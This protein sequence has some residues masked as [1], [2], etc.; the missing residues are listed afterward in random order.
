MKSKL[1]PHSLLKTSEILKKNIENQ[2]HLV[3]IQ[4]KN[5]RFKV[6]SKENYGNF[7][8]VEKEYYTIKGKLEDQNSFT[9]ISYQVN[10]NSIFNT[11]SII[12]PIMALP[13]AIIPMIS[14]GKAY[15]FASLIGYLIVSS[16]LIIIFKY[17]EKL[18]RVK[19]EKE[20]EIFL[21]NIG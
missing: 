1:I 7:S 21:N 13:T 8:L 19:G 9:Q 5:N 6:V 17:Q 20:F 4:L 2:A 3:L 16:L 11:L 18:L 14:G 10:G 15:L 12:I